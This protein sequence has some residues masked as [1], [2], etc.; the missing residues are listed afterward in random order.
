[1]KPEKSKLNVIIYSTVRLYNG[2]SAASARVMN[3][4]RALAMKCKVFLISF[5][6]R[7]DIC[8]N[9]K[10][11]I[12]PNIFIVGQHKNYGNKI[13]RKVLKPF[14]ILKFFFDINIFT[15]ELNNK[16]Y[17]LY[18]STEVFLDYF[19]VIVLKYFKKKNVFIELNEVRKYSSFLNQ[20]LSLLKKPIKY[21]HMKKLYLKYNLSEKLVRYFDGAIC[22]SSNIEKYF[23]KF[24]KNILRIPILANFSGTTKTK[25]NE[26]YQNDE[27]K[28]GFFGSVAYKKENFDLL[29]KSLKRIKQV[30]PSQK[31]KL[32]LYGRISINEQK[33]LLQKLCEYSLVNIVEYKSELLQSKVIEIMNDYHLLILPRGNTLQNKYGFSTK[34]SE[35]LIS[36]TPTLVTNISDNAIYIKDSFN[37]FIVEPDDF[38][39]MSNKIL[40]IIKNYNLLSKDIG[41]NAVETIER[42]FDYK[43]YSNKLWKFLC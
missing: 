36:G 19:S 6:D 13:S 17:L 20:D 1:M 42:H 12:E 7:N 33:H 31:I 38:E 26:Y 10:K 40:F 18:P 4:A 15:R 41:Y 14:F 29:F 11:E 5:Y 37:G 9:N 32:D 39:E 25:R 35:Y 23:D 24:N 43:L 8:F 30:N 16:V 27:F 28:I 21:L 22:I 2:N 3:Y 34:L